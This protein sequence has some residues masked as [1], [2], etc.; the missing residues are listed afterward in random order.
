[1]IYKEQ[2]IQSTNFR[3]DHL[4]LNVFSF[5]DP[6]QGQDQQASSALPIQTE[7][8]E[9]NLPATQEQR[10]VDGKLMVVLIAER[11][12]IAETARRV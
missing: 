2:K 12:L 5:D 11:M 10:E 3:F 6:D 7:K 4:Y 8:G 9:I 1:M